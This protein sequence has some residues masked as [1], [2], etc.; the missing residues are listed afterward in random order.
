MKL[1]K[2]QLEKDIETIYDMAERYRNVVWEP[3]EGQENHF[4]RLTKAEKV[5]IIGIFDDVM[6]L[7]DS[8]LSYQHWFEE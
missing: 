7:K 3:Q 5:A 4:D 2:E 6:K 8:L 1:N